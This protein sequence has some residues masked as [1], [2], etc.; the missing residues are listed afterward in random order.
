MAWIYDPTQYEENDF[1]IIPIGDHRLRVEEVTAKTFKSGNE[2][3]EIVFAVS[4]Y[5]SK[6]WFYLTLDTSDPK[7]TNQRLGEFFGSFGI[8]DYNTDHYSAW[9]GKVGAAKIKHEDYNGEAQAKVRY[10]IGRAKQDKLPPWKESGH[11]AAPSAPAAA[12]DFAEL[13]D[14][15]GDDELPF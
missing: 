3:F 6:I 1:P 5:N 4:G 14:D 12:P 2:G 7:K 9:V 13:P 15:D 11:T 10:F 8:T